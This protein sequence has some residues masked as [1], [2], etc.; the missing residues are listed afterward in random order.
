[1]LLMHK[2]EEVLL[3]LFTSSLGGFALGVTLGWN[4]STGEVLRNILNAGSTEI[5]LIGSI[6]NAG[7]CIGVMS[8]P[9]FIKYLS[10]TTII[11][12]TIP[13]FIV[14]WTFI[15]SAGQK[16]LLLIIGRFICG[17]SGGVFCILTPIYI[18]EI[19]DK[20][21]REQ[22]LMYFH[23]LINC[24][25]MYA[26]VIAHILDEQDAIWRYSLICAVPCLAI[27]LINLVP[28]S[29]LY[30]LAKNNEIKAKDCLK[31]YRGEACEDN[32]EMEELKY[33]AVACRSKM[34]TMSI[35]K[36]RHIISSFCTCFF[37]FLA[38]QLSGVNTI[39]FYALTFFN[40]GGSGNITASEQTIVISSIQILSCFLAMSLINMVGRRILLIVSASLMGLFL[41]L[42]GW[43]YE[44]RDY[45]PEYDDIYFWMP[46][47]WIALFFAAFN[48]GIGPISWALLGDIFPMQIRETAV[49]CAATF[50]WLLCLIATMSF[51][52]MVVA[53]GVTKSMW[54]FAGFCWL[55]GILCAFFVKDTRGHSLAKIQKS[56]GIDNRQEET[57]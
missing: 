12:L 4:S 46:P 37:A 47:T 56:F 27:A 41:M 39:I 33:L 22:L 38:Q 20:D 26:F 23:L 55:A 30:Y 10:R 32:I 3:D 57:T 25:I 43:F 17:M 50:N 1:M 11:F 28:E 16:I 21:L 6:L 53:L 2:K 35:L 29:P 7:A 19:A 44:L 8:V 54:L 15:C 13:G 5:G 36:N 40:I 31:W 51:G 52:E 18:A 42:L 14:G 48:I 45:D 34:S 49:A 24:G 9:F